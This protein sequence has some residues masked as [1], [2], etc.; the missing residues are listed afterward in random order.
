MKHFCCLITQLVKKTT[1]MGDGRRYPPVGLE[2]K[3]VSEVY[4]LAEIFSKQFH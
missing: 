4:L 1:P 3:T 2:Y